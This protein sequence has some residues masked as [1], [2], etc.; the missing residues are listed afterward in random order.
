VCLAKHYHPQM[1]LYRRALARILQA[2]ERIIRVDLAFLQ[3]DRLV[4]V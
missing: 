1:A 3:A 2:P 4:P